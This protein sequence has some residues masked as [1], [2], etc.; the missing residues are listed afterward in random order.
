MP[1]IH[2]LVTS[3]NTG[4]ISPRLAARTDFVK[5]PSSFETMENLLPLAEGAMVRR[6]GSRYISEIVDSTKKSR[7][8]GFEFSTTQAYVI[9]VDDSLFRFYRDQQLITVLTTDA[10]ITNGTF[11]SDTTGWTQLVA[12]VSWNAG[13]WMD[14]SSSAKAEQSVTIGAGNINNEHVMNFRVIGAPGD[15]IT[16]GVGTSTGAS[17]VLNF[18]AKVGY[19]SVAFTPGATTIYINFLN[20]ASKTLGVDDVGFQSNQGVQLTT[21]WAIAKAFEVDGP[22]SADVLYLFHKDVWPYKLERRGH[23]FWSLVQVFWVDGP[24]FDVNTTAT[25]MTPSATTGNAITVTASAVTGINDDTGFQATD[26]YRSIRIDNQSPGVEWGWGIIVEVTSTTAVKVDIKRDF[27]T[28]NADTRWRIGSWS[29][30]TGYPRTATF[31]EGRLFA[32]GTTEQ[33]QTLWGS[34]TDVFED[35]SPDSPNSSDKW[36]G[37]V[38][39]DDSLNFT[40]SANNVNAILWMRANQ[41]NMV[42]GTTGGEWVPSASG[43]VLTPTDFAAKRQTTH[44]SAA[45]VQPIAVGDVVLFLQRSKRKIREFAFNFQSDGFKAFDMTRLAQHITFGG[46]NQMAFAEEPDSVLWA[47]R[48]DGQLLSMTYRRDEDSVGWARHKLGGA[49]SGGDTVVESIETIPGQ[50]GSGQVQ[51]STNRNEVWMIVKRTINGATKRYVE[52]LERDFE[53]GHNAGDAYYLDSSITYSGAATVTITG[54]D[55]LEGE[56]V[57]IWADGAIHPDKTVASGQITLDSAETPV[58]V[59][60]RYKHRLKT[61]KIEGGNPVGTALGKTKQIYKI[62]FILL[63]S[64]TIRFGRDDNNMTSNEFRKVADLMD[65][66]V[67]LFTGE[68][69]PQFED[70]WTTDSRLIIDSDDPAPFTL[71]AIAPEISMNPLK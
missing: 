5:Y 62:T 29:G 13:G 16:L 46:V 60:L 45:D 47:V 59:G 4:E 44:G 22:Q 43:V 27:L 66:A 3:F 52:V 32:A 9:E 8:K 56:T 38:E 30:T 63:N 69:S 58:Q 39:D 33:P 48:D 31:Y 42:I 36:D 15:E 64:H 40:L 17:D 34:Q 20:N 71:L 25:T 6:A 54:L 7:L 11:D 2:P 28:T 21:P 14:L 37:T 35:F 26:L 23:R 1:R 53:D 10:A 68:F 24:W 49:F 50:N 12:T 65:T 61:L 51:D 41:D 19:H 67:P 70:R 57:G 18:K 55:H